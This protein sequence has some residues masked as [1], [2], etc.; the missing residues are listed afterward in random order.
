[1]GVSLYTVKQHHLPSNRI[2]TSLRMK[3]AVLFSLVVLLLVA[4]L[5]PASGCDC[6]KFLSTRDQLPTTLA[7]A[8]VKNPSCGTNAACAKAACANASADVKKLIKEHIQQHCTGADCA[9]TTC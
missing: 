2:T 4:F 1:M 7:E 6:V 5:R 8:G 3:I 9:G